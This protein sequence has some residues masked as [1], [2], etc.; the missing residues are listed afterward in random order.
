MKKILVTGG[1]GFIGS[2]LVK[3]LI[4]AGNEVTVL[5]NLCRGN[6]LDK[7]VLAAVNFIE[8][9][10][11][12]FD[13]VKK[14]VKGCDTIYHFAAVLGVDIV[15]DN[16][17]ETME[18][19]T[20][21]MQNIVSAAIAA[22]VGKIVYASTSGVYGHSAITRSV[23]EDITVD[24][25][26]SYAIAKRFNEIYLAATY[27]EKG[28]NAISVRFFN[29]YGRK[30][31]K[32]MVIPRF[33]EQALKN[34]PITVYGEGMQT[35]DFTFIDDTVKACMLLEEKVQGCEIVNIAHDDEQSI[36]I[37]A[38]KIKEVTGSTSEII[39]VASPI[40]RYDFEVERRVGCSDKLHGLVGYKPHT[41]LEEGLTSFYNS[42]KA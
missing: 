29:V 4:E 2:N 37:L 1:A 28:L 5:D 11:R 15:A 14:A 42:L 10:V 17:M 26:T 31:D 9:D 24:P 38:E 34:E 41:S 35:R 21:G 39:Q 36:N 40:K 12:N 25:R 6:K 8:G 3:A 33:F 18:T 16:P 30:Q 19:E 7:D 22:G 27:E 32:R 13:T 23:T 20:I